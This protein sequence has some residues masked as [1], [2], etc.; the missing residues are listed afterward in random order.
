VTGLGLARVIRHIADNPAE[1][2]AVQRSIDAYARQ[3]M[4]RLNVGAW[5]KTYL[6]K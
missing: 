4:K 1:I 3:F 6:K 5:A 2:A